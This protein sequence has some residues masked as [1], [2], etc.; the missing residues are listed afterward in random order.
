M[1]TLL[2]LRHAKSSQDAPSGIDLD[3]PLNPRGRSQ[4]LALGRMM[5]ERQIAVDAII[6]SPAARV[7]ETLSGVL[8]GAGT[9][10]EPVFD[11]R[12]YNASPEALLEV[13]REA[14]DKV[15]RLLI[16]GHNPGLQHLL[17]HLGDQDCDGLRAN[18]AAN[19]PTATLAELRLSVDYWRDG[20][21]HSGRIASLVRPED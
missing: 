18:V 20:G 6:A 8:E 3:R 10:I 12:L 14:D 11:P 15:G 13:I 17:L 21:R 2:V 1:K 16:V 9:G 4:A 5:R 19:F 7:A